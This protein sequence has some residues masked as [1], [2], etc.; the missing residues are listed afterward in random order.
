MGITADVIIEGT[1]DSHAIRVSPKINPIYIGLPE[2]SS[3]SL[4]MEK[5]LYFH[6]YIY[7]LDLNLNKTCIIHIKLSLKI[8]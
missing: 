7:E 4:F 2:M 6:A 1:N 3:L 8:H 5:K